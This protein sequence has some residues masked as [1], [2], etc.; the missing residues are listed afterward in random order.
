MTFT[1]RI[2][3][4]NRAYENEW[5]ALW[6]PWYQE[7]VTVF[8]TVIPT[9]PYITITQEFLETYILP[10]IPIS[11]QSSIRIPC[12]RMHVTPD[13]IRK[14]KHLDWNWTDLTYNEN[15]PIQAIIN[16]LDL[17]WD[18]Q[19]ILNRYDITPEL[20]AKLP[21]DYS[22]VHGASNP[23]LIKHILKHPELYDVTSA[24][25]NPKITLA[26]IERHIDIFLLRGSEW[27][28]S[29]L[30][31]LPITTLDFILKYRFLINW[32]MKML[33]K[34]PNLTTNF[35]MDHIDWDWDWYHISLHPMITPDFVRANSNTLPFDW[36]G[37]MKN[38][39]IPIEFI[40]ETID[41]YAWP[42]PH[43]RFIHDNPNFR[44][45]HIDMFIA[46]N[47]TSMLN[48]QTANYIMEHLV[49]S[50]DQVYH[51]AKFLRLD[52]NSSLRIAVG[53]NPNITVEMM[54]IHSELSPQI[55]AI[56]MANA[57]ATMQYISSTLNNHN[58]NHINEHRLTK[59]S[60]DYDKFITR[61]ICEHMAAY[62]IQGRWR[63]VI[64][65]PAYAVCRRKLEYDFDTTIGS[66]CTGLLA[67]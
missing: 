27:Y 43:F 17:P 65:N 50:I 31:S 38:P 7:H 49:K 12:A 64:C 66:V 33:S 9:I 35:L 3:E 25:T 46:L 24:S 20:L 11:E 41:K 26:F 16:N 53:N 48:T 15:I 45:E 40:I 32:D 22:S 34:N 63:E 28:L 13:F 8:N 4:A 55:R 42:G 30:A 2:A 56:F 36:F 67:Q 47:L 23:A 61:K 19:C 10:K 52:V 57:N 6:W 60:Y 59:M 54:N 39:S 44:L 29:N 18:M 62:K 14:H 51:Y 5:L 37:M 21:I 58:H 1:E